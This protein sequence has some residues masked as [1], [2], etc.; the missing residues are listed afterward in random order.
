M[1]SYNLIKLL[2]RGKKNSTREEKYGLWISFPVRFPIRTGSA[3][4]TSFSA[5]A[6]GK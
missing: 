5:L 6:W 4:D 2:L 3:D 1:V